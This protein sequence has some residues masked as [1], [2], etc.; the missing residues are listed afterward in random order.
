MKHLIFLLVA[1]DQKWILFS[2][3]AVI[4][5]NLESISGNIPEHDN[6]IA[7]VT[8]HQQGNRTQSRTQEIRLSFADEEAGW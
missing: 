7:P 3:S 1:V 8:I 6:C 2:L 4:C 5:D